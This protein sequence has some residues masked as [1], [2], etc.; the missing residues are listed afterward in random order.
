[1]QAFDKITAPAIPLPLKDIDTDMIIPAQFLTSIEKEG[2]GENL[3][4]RLR[5][6]QADFP[7]NLEKYKNAKIL[8]T[9][10]NFGC[11]SS[12]EHAVWALMGWGIRVVI[13]P[14]FADIF[15]ANSAK[16]GLLLITVSEEEINK[17]LE[18]ANFEDYEFTVDLKNQQLLLPDGK[19]INFHIDPFRKMCLLKGYDELDY[20]LSN[21]EEIKK[22]KTKRNKNFYYST[23]PSNN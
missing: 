9:K 20:L 21:L 5:D 4:R 2:F 11:G 10:S 8:I 15:F 3:F 16:N 22:F 7:F 19:I 23:T 12:R 14:S 17:M 13:A 6:E 1:M 18:E